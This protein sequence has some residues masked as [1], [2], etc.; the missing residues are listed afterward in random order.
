MNQRHNNRVARWTQPLALASTVLAG[1]LAG[2]MVLIQV[3][4][5]PFWRTTPPAEF[6]R[7]FVANVDRLRRLMVP[8]GAAAG[9]VG[10]AS[11]ITQLNG[12]RGH[13]GPSAAAA[14]ATGGVIAIT[15]A[16]NEPANHRF[17]EGALTDSETRDLLR[18]WARWHDVRVVLGLAA[19][20]A[21]ASALSER[22]CHERVLR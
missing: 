14:V 20:V 4:L 12:R 7:W 22:R 11:A 3:V 19:T 8:L 9:V 21:A 18:R 6:R 10:A 16:V 13:G 2:G 5:V 17:T 1:V 15:L